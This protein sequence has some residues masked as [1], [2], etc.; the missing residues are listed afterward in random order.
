MEQVK[1]YGKAVLEQAKKDTLELVEKKAA[2]VEK[3][4]KELAP[5]ATGALRDS[6][7]SE[8]DKDELTARIGS[9]LDYALAVELGTARRAAKPYLRPALE[10]AKD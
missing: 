10:K 8:V 3:D 7:T 1:W 5:V 4:A 9:D 6:I 2:Q